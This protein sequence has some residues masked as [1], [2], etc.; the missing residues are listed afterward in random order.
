MKA[1]GRLK[2]PQGWFAAGEGFRRALGLLSDGA[3]KL[4]AWICLHAERG[5]GELA[6]ERAGL[7]RSLGK[8]RSALGRHLAEL[9][10][11]GVC[12]IEPAPN[13]HRASR[14]RVL[15]AFWPYEAAPPP[16]GAAGPAA[17]EAPHGSG[18]AYV[19]SVRRLLAGPSCVQGP[20]T[21]ADERLAAAWHR[22]GVP[23]ET[24]R[25]AF[26][27]GCVRKSFVLIDRPDA[28]P[29]GSLR[30]FEGLLEEVRDASFPAAYWQHVEFNLGRCEQYWRTRPATAPGRRR[31]QGERP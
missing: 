2:Q 11:K 15:P 4:F 22:A 12:E 31:C 1:A 5:S 6:F 7:A 19:E 30:Y 3:F 28:Q 14:L 18:A 16:H 17:P 27:L 25:R 29:I 13:Q 20:F 8:S 26:L 23:L 9:A 24:V 21:A 10:A